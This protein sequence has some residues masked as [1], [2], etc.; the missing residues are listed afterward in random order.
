MGT[1]YVAPPSWTWTF[2][3]GAKI[4]L[5]YISTDKGHLGVSRPYDLTSASIRYQQMI[6]ESDVQYQPAKLGRR[7]W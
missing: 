1:T 6:A 7:R 5:A 3:S 2:P 4:R